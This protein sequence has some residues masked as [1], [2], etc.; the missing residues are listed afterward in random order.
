M[1]Q[2]K[3]FASHRKLLVKRGT[4]RHKLKLAMTFVLVWS[5]LKPT[6]QKRSTWLPKKMYLH[7]SLH[8]DVQYIWLNGLEWYFGLGLEEQ[9]QFMCYCCNTRPSIFQEKCILCHIR[10][11]RQNWWHQGNGIIRHKFVNL[12]YT[13]RNNLF[14]LLYF[15]STH[16]GFMT[17]NH[18]LFIIMRGRRYQFFASGMML[19]HISI[20]VSMWVNIS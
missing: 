14:N 18:R 3:S 11:R 20:F 15:W 9:I 13:I 6:Q 10:P 16:R 19:S 12:G 2:L 4:S 8:W 7:P 1:N 17:Y 5:G